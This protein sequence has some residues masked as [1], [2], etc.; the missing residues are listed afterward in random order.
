MDVKKPF[1]YM[2]ELREGVGDPAESNRST[3]MKNVGKWC[4]SDGKSKLRRVMFHKKLD[5]YAYTGYFTDDVIKQIEGDSKV[6]RCR[7]QSR[8]EF[9]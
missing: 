7:K 3:H 4:A 8:P 6:V 2:V 9:C 1:V 5:Y